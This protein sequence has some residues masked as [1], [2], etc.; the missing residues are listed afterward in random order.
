MIKRESSLNR[1]EK[2]EMYTNQD[3]GKRK[4][5]YY[6][7]HNQTYLALSNSLT[8]PLKTHFVCSGTGTHSRA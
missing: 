8:L 4:K 3:K 2:E 6:S 1:K 7:D 5:N